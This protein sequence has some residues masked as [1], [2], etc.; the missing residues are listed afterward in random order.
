MLRIGENKP[1]YLQQTIDAVYEHYKT[2]ILKPTVDS[3]FD[4]KDISKAHERLE[5]RKS[6]GKVV[7]KW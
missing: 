3:V 7:V 1:D 4:A 6:T 5:G 2:G